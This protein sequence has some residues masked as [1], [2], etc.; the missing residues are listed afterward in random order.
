MGKEKKRRR[1]R[2]E[3][4]DERGGSCVGERG[5]RFYRKPEQYRGDHAVE[6]SILFKDD[7]IVSI[8]LASFHGGT[9][10]TATKYLELILSLATDRSITEFGKD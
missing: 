9:F 2:G 8:P 6:L 4:R 7:T 10:L 5:R 1:R 3:E